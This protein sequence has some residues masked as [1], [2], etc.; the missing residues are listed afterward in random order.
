MADD[1]YDTDIDYISLKTV[2]VGE[3]CNKVNNS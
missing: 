1:E 2:L 3:T